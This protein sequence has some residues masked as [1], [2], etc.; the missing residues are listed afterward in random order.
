MILE[1]RNIPALGPK[2]AALQYH[3][4]PPFIITEPATNKIFPFPGV[5]ITAEA[6]DKFLQTYLS[7]A[8]Q[9]YGMEFGQRQDDSVKEENSSQVLLLNSQSAVLLT[10]LGDDS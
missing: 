10:S 1:A 4:V 3:Q 9:N 6:I 5:I 2:V 7:G 8:L